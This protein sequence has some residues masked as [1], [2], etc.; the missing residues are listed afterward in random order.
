VRAGSLFLFGAK[1]NGMEGGDG[2]GI[3]VDKPNSC[4]NSKSSKTDFQQ[5]LWKPKHL[6]A[7]FPMR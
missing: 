1:G 4:G 2:E 5:N 6:S 7:I 3:L